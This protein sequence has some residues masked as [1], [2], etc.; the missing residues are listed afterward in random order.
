MALLSLVGDSSVWLPWAVE[1]GRCIALLHMKADII[2]GDLTTS[3]LMIRTVGVPSLPTSSDSACSISDTLQPPPPPSAGDTPLVANTFEVVFID[4]G[5]GL[6]KS[7][8]ED[9]AV[10]LYVL[11]RAFASTHPGMELFMRYIVG[12]HL[13][14]LFAI[15][16]EWLCIVLY[17]NLTSSLLE[18]MVKL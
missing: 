3:N 17:W 13:H 4:F 1:I 16:D 2:H 18:Q 5:L 8:Q 14:C 7:S 9:K 12:L 15:A 10:D 11:E 6:M